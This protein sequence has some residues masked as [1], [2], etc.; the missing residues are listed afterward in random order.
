[1]RPARQCGRRDRRH[2]PRLYAGHADARRARRIPR[3]R[4]DAGATGRRTAR[5]AALH[6]ATTERAAC[7][8]PVHARLRPSP[9]ARTDGGG[10]AAPT[11]RAS[12]TSRRWS[13]KHVLVRRRDS[14]PRHPARAPSSTAAM[15]AR[16]SRGW[17]PAAPGSVARSSCPPR[18][19]SS[20]RRRAGIGLELLA[21]PRRHVIKC[22]VNYHPADPVELR[23]AQEARLA[24]L[25]DA[26]SHAR[27]RVADRGH[28]F[29]GP[30]ARSTRARRR[31]CCSGSTTSACGPPGGS[32]RRRPRRPGAR[33]PR[34]SPPATR[35]A[36]ACCCS[37]SMPAKS[38][39]RSPSRSPRGHP[40][41]PRL[42]DRPHDLRR[43]G[44]GL[45]RG[46]RSTI[47]HGASRESAPRVRAHDRAP[48]G[49]AARRAARPR[50]E[51][52]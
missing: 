14:A 37:G 19:R 29:G 20:S 3:P 38:R 44:A 6:R 35:S 24:E 42:R 43:A 22:L 23:L 11:M 51:L 15:A 27:A 8:R 28:L 1:M 34:S 13:P 49:A 5:I 25:A 31:P 36:T 17:Q 39:S 47:A 33:S 30:G 7:G 26:T 46:T 45:A 50:E 4:R 21:W 16:R 2:P 9:P 40:D 10:R 48:G 12:R 32:S 18:G 52:K 41:L